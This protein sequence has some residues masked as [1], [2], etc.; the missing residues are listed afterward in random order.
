[1]SFHQAG[2]AGM[3]RVVDRKRIDKLQGADFSLLEIKITG[4]WRSRKNSWV[5]PPSLTEYSLKATRPRRGL[6]VSPCSCC[7]YV[8]SVLD[9]YCISA[10]FPY[11]L[12]SLKILKKWLRRMMPIAFLQN[13]T[14]SSGY[15]FPD[16]CTRCLIIGHSFHGD[17][18][19]K[20]AWIQKSIVPPVVHVQ[21]P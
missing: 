20:A 14:C 10:Y 19:L 11:L 17:S 21:N 18:V 5:L 4:K 1:M 15:I 16:C 13:N 3:I 7:V 12:L 6:K 9:L 8:A 2:K